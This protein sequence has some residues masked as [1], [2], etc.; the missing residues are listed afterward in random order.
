MVAHHSHAEWTGLCLHLRMVY[1]RF[2]YLQGPGTYYV[3]HGHSSLLV[4]PMHQTRGPVPHT[5]QCLERQQ[6]NSN[7]LTW[8][9]HVVD[10]YLSA[11]CELCTKQAVYS[12]HDFDHPWGETCRC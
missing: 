10:E 12:A 9:F 4:A 5:G 1:G 6:V 11:C 7:H 8:Q 3:R 2:P